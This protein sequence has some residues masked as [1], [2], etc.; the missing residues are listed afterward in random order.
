MELSWE[1]SLHRKR[2]H[3]GGQPADTSRHFSKWDLESYYKGETV[4]L[5]LLVIYHI[6]LVAVSRPQRLMACWPHWV[7]VQWLT[8]GWQL[9]SG[10]WWWHVDAL[11]VQL[12]HTRIALHRHLKLD[13]FCSKQILETGFWR[14]LRS[15]F[16]TFNMKILQMLLLH[17]LFSSWDI[18][19]LLGFSLAL[20]LSHVRN[21]MPAHSHA[22]N[23][24]KAAPL[25]G[26]NASEWWCVEV[27]C[28]EIC[29]LKIIITLTGPDSKC[30]DLIV[31]SVIKDRLLKG[32]SI[33]IGDYC[34]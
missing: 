16:F 27:V 33:F 28:C 13:L 1:R 31:T 22:V 18:Y 8:V 7:N 29:F 17:I 20:R 5:K 10:G 11:V 6:S 2:P 12:Q 23:C 15:L 4:F 25:S 30:C 26:H 14:S 19:I 24:V 9:V 32:E 21:N 34:L 3:S